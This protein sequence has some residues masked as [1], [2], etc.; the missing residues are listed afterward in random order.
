MTDCDSNQ[1]LII[2]ILVVV[3]VILL[4]QVEQYRNIL[5]IMVYY[6]PESPPPKELMFSSSFLS[7]EPDVH[8]RR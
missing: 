4:F 3:C 1:A 7:T 5:A 2:G 8:A 6:S